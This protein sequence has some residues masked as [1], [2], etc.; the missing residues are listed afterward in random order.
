MSQISSLRVSMIT[1]G[2][3]PR[4]FRYELSRR[5]ILRVPWFFESRRILNESALAGRE[6]AT[7]ERMC[8]QRNRDVP[9][10][11]PACAQH[12]ILGL[13][14]CP[15]R[16]VEAQAPLIL[17]KSKKSTSSKILCPASDRDVRRSITPP[18]HTLPRAASLLSYPIH[19]RSHYSTDLAY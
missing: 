2:D 18:L 9:E 12:G 8:L 15:Q 4:Y 11:S 6:I 5:S 17:C 16:T 3:S 1:A 13:L 10:C 7:G 14:N 19:Q